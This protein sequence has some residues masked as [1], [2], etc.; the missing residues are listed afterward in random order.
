MLRRT[1]RIAA[2]AIAAVALLAAAPAG[3]ITVTSAN[4][5]CAPDA[6][7]CLVTSPMDIPDGFCTDNPLATC[8]SNNDCALPAYC[9]FGGVLLDFGVRDVQVSGAGQFNFGTA[10]GAIHCGDFT[11]S[12]TNPAIDA[13]G[14]DGNGSDS[15]TVKLFARRKCSVGGTGAPA[16]LTNNECDGGTCDKRRCSLNPARV[17]TSDD[18]CQVG[19]CKA[20]GLKFN[21]SVD[22]TIQCRTNADCNLGTCPAQLTCSKFAT[23]PRNC[24][25]NTDCNFG[26]CSVGTGAVTLGGGSASAIVGN[27]EFPAFI[28]IRAADDITLTKNIN[29]AGT[30]AESDGG[31]LSMDSTFGSIIIGGSVSVTSGGLSTGGDVSLYAGNDVV[32]NDIIDVSGG[33]YDGGTVDFEAGRDLLVNRS[34][35]GSSGSGAGYGGEYLL[36]AGRDLIVTG[37]SAA[38]K[39]SL[40]TNGHANAFNDAGDGGAQDLAADRNLTLQVNTRIVTNGAAP[41][42]TGGDVALD[43][44]EAMTLSGDITS[45]GLG[46]S[47]AGGAVEGFASGVL[48][49]TAS[50]T[51]DLT[52]G[53]DAGGDLALFAEKELNYG[54]L[55]DLG[56]SNGG[57][58]GSAT[59][60]SDTTATVTGTVRNSVGDG[61]DVDVR[62]CY[63]TLTSTGQLDLNLTDSN[64]T[65]RA[66]EQIRVNAGSLMKAGPLGSNRIEYRTNAKAPIVSGTV[67]PGAQLVLD[68]TL[69]GCIICGN[70]TL[71]GGETCEDSNTVN[72]D[73]C[74]SN[75][76]NEACVAQTAPVK[77]CTVNADCGP[78][79]C[80][81]PQG[82]RLC[83]RWKVCEDGNFCTTDSCNDALDTCTHTAKVCN[84]SIPCTADSC[85]PDT[86]ACV[87]DPNDAA[88]ADTN[89]CTDE[90]CDVNL[91]CVLSANTD[92]CDDGIGCTTQDTCS[93][94]ACI[95]IPGEGCGFCGDGQVNNNEACD[96][97]N[98]TFAN[99]EYCGVNCAAIP[100]GKPFGGA[101]PVKSSDAQYILRSAVGQVPCSLRVCDTD[102]STKI[103]ATDANR[104]LR[105]AVGQD[106]TLNCPTTGS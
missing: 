25:S 6:D 3:A 78:Y 82:N 94:Q 47:G 39:T 27:S 55:A 4:Q 81:G 60:H 100:C 35:L 57:T 101:L 76:Q 59:L 53:S 46:A 20:N 58:G 40:E 104:V 13:N 98:A 72:G 50:G 86:G 67:S 1:S 79:K 41:D 88:C 24:A 73:G 23:N 70:G 2:L 54:G 26:S 91:G 21:C 33:D 17:C 63:I 32:L 96:D 42:A 106:V 90:T 14:L 34:I 92:P 15:G 71:E 31:E 30:T 84:D 61:A 43:S 56:A 97:G 49:V 69:F 28:D 87:K 77:S 89:V 37:V 51:F 52:G 68:D 93:N 48:N 29:L 12:T 9:K 18:S 103:V 7:P 62:A 19:F 8:S 83:D 75:C 102:N 16:C 22:T 45:K 36:V 44:G 80:V 11:A 5:V 105:K 85:N 65:L 10:S 64:N 74:N 66:D 38:S 95:G 99:G